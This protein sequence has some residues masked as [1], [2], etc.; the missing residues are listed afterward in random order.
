MTAVTAGC[1]TAVMI[2]VCHDSGDSGH[3]GHSK[4]AVYSEPLKK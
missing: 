4:T 1:V 2:A 3:S